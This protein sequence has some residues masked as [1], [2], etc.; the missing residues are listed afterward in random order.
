M[1]VPLLLVGLRMYIENKAFVAKYVILVKRLYIFNS[2]LLSLSVLSSSSF[3]IV[4]IIIYI[5]D[6]NF[7]T[8]HFI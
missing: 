6:V 1:H 4:Q 5:K 3:I 8:K 2:L 7:I